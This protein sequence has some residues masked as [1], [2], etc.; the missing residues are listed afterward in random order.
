RRNRTLADG[1][2]K[3]SG[4]LRNQRGLYR[5]RNERFDLSHHDHQSC[6]GRSRYHD[7]DVVFQ[8]WNQR[9]ETEYSDACLALHLNHVINLVDHTAYAGS[10]FQLN[11]VTNATQTQTTQ[12]RLVL[13][14]TAD[15]AASLSYFYSVSHVALPQNFFNAQTTLGSDL[16][17]GL[18]LY[19][20]VYSCANNVDWVGGTVGLSQHVVNTSNFQ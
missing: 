7:H 1:F 18:T 2:S 20:S 19:Q 14:Q 11:G 10:I 16:G 3:A 15:R 4:R 8:A 13:W 9:P 5:H 6:P 17:R 12:S